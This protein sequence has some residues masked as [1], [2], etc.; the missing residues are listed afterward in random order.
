MDL[1]ERIKN[2]GV[3]KQ[4]IAMKVGITPCNFSKWLS[5]DYVLTSREIAEIE[6]LVSSI[7]NALKIKA[8]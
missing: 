4:F 7:E 3:K 2:I 5:N 8:N 6:S 1:Q